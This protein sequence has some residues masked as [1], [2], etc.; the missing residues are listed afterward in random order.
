[1]FGVTDGPL[2][3]EVTRNV[4]CIDG[5]DHRRL[6]NLVNPS[7]TARAVER[8]RPAIRGF[9]AELWEKVAAAG[10]CEFVA[11]CSKPYPAGPTATGRGPPLWRAARLYAWS[12]WIQKQF[13][14]EV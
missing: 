5:A 9:L 12:N 1:M 7:L 4:L 2:H 3:E 10:R 14:A 8:Y 6:R 13:A 11:D